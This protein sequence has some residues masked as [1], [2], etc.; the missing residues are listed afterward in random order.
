MSFPYHDRNWV[1]VV[2]FLEPRLRD[3]DRVLAPDRFWW[4]LSRPVHRWVPA[5]LSPGARYDWVVVH[6][7]EL[8]QFPRAFVAGL[9]AAM[10]PVLANEVFVVHGRPDR[11]DPAR[12]PGADDAHLASYE[13]IVAGLPPTPAEPN[14]CLQ[15]RVLGDD[16]VLGRFADMDDGELRRAENEFFERGGYGYVTARDRGYF[17]DVHE[18]LAA[19]LGRWAGGRVLDIGCGSAAFGPVP[20]A[21]TVVRSDFAAVGVA[22]ARAADLATGTGPGRCLHATVDG[23]RLAFAVASFDAVSFVD[24]IEHV[25]DAGGVLRE[26]ARVLRPGGELLLTFANRDSLHLV[27]TR[28]LGYP[29]FMTNHQHIREFTL[30]EVVAL[31]DDAGFDLVSTAGV[32][33]LPYWG[34][35][36]IDEVVR[37]ITDDDPEVVE[38]LR[39][40]GRRVGAEHAY[41]GVVLARRRVRGRPVPLA[42][43]GPSR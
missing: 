32:S 6:K 27:L 40:L 31:L 28:K 25:R 5:N 41:A 18:H 34:V 19:A 11:A 1:D 43:G 17:E 30:G 20:A 21:T 33:L 29:E 37:P 13:A 35:P 26:A 23:H 38:L 36:G 14:T 10:V 15:D 4:R 12:A 22:L 2:A 39:E 9:G 7:G 16:R 42:T 3:E 24:A 8:G